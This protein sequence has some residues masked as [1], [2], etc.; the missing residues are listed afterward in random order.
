MLAQPGY[1]QVEIPL[2]T[3]Q[4]ATVSVKTSLTVYLAVSGKNTGKAVIICPGGG[5]Q[6]LVTKR[7]GTDIA[8][9]FS[10]AGITAIVLKYRIPAESTGLSKWYEPLQDAQEALKVLRKRAAQWNINPNQI[11]IMGFSAGGHLAATVGTHF[12]HPVLINKEKINLRP[13]FMVLVYPVISFKDSITHLGSRNHLIGPENSKGF[14]ARVDEFSNEL[15]VSKATP[16]TFLT[17]AADDTVVPIGH[18]MTFYD[19]LRRHGIP[20]DLH[21]YNKG[22]H[23]FLKYPDFEDWFNN[24]L[25]WIL[26]L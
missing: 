13:D 2:Y 1:A 25:K 8:M 20:V 19:S 14:K 10:K 15:H 18:T 7:E 24:C 3:D 16:P 11:G 26:N 9:A 5:Y 23:G 12:D 22:E 6:G 17:H 21:I 4:S